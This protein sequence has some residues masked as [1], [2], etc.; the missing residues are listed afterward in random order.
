MNA[1]DT[2]VAVMDALRGCLCD[3]LARLDAPVC[4]CALVP[5]AQAFADACSCG[6]SGCGMAWVRLDRIYPSRNFPLQDQ[7]ASPC[8]SPLAAV[9]EVGVLRC[10]PTLKA[11]GQPPTAVELTQAAIDQGRDAGAMLAA[12][13]CCDAIGD[14][15][16]T[17]GLYV[18]RDAADCGGGA[19][20]VTVQLVRR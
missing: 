19:W 4:S 15:P 10:V 2:A 13:N 11:G 12:L 20:T 7:T 9:I 14:R 8:N 3:E 18:P 5:G 6:N 1:V 17:L 16:H